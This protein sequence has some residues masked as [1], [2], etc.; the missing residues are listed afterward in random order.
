MWERKC[1]SERVQMEKKDG[2]NCSTCTTKRQLLLALGGITE[3]TRLGRFARENGTIIS[4]TYFWNTFCIRGLIIGVLR[5][6]VRLGLIRARWRSR[7][8]L[9]RSGSKLQ[10]YHTRGIW[11]RC[12]CLAQTLT[13]LSTVLVRIIIICV[14]VQD[15]FIHWT[16]IKLIDWKTHTRNMCMEG[17]DVEKR[18]KNI[19]Q[20]WRAKEK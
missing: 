3:W 15:A 5:E 16:L 1:E 10:A 11:N 19:Q 7:F 2:G 20:N 4:Y 13:P 9:E 14:L 18:L 6:R 17:K 8:F 12:I